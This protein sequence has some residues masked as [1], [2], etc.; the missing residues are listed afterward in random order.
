M[1]SKKEG[2]AES[3]VNMYGYNSIAELW[4]AMVVGDPVLE[5]LISGILCLF[6]LLIQALVERYLLKGIA[7]IKM[8]WDRKKSG[9]AKPSSKR[10]KRDFIDE[11]NQMHDNLIRFLRRAEFFPVFMVIMPIAA[12]IYKGTWRYW[13]RVARAFQLYIAEMRSYI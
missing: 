1:L 8:M 5:F 2:T 10:E 7:H 6:L 11:T 9:K 12:F 3:E 13:Q 4:N